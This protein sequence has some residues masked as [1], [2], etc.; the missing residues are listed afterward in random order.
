MKY[1]DLRKL[2]LQFARANKPQKLNGPEYASEVCLV[3]FMT[4][5][6]NLTLHTPQTT[7]LL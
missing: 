4:G 6:S 1:W 2:A 3:G 7:S 5:N